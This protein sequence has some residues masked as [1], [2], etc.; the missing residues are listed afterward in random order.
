MRVALQAFPQSHQFYDAR[1]WIAPRHVLHRLDR[2]RHDAEFV[3]CSDAD[4]CSSEVDSKR[5]VWG[6]LSEHFGI[7]IGLILHRSS[8]TARNSQDW[9]HR[10]VGI[11]D[12][13][14]PFA[15]APGFLGSVVEPAAHRDGLR[16]TVL[17]EKW[18]SYPRCRTCSDSGRRFGCP[19]IPEYL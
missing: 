18:E 14:D 15:L 17:D 10:I 5:W 7:I 11:S 13:A 6:I 12:R 1:Q 19:Q 4:S 2:M 16:C 9:S 8:S 3:R